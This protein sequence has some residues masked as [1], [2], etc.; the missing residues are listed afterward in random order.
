WAMTVAASPLAGLGMP[1]R[2]K[3]PG[4]VVN[5]GVRRYVPDGSSA[6][7]FDSA[8]NLEGQARVAAAMRCSMPNRLGAKPPSFAPNDSPRISMISMPIRTRESR[9]RFDVIVSPAAVSRSLE[10]ANGRHSIRHN[11]AYPVSRQGP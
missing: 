8:H 11:S 3:Y 10:T 5:E 9:L 1:V 6:T 2:K 4:P 7:I